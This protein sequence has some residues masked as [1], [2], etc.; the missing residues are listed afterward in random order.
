MFTMGNGMRTRLNF[1][2]FISIASTE[3][4][5][6]EELAHSGDLSAMV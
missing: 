4:V 2:D 3:A 6:K 5:A 1:S